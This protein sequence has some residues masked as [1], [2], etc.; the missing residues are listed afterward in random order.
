MISGGEMGLPRPETRG[1]GL[2]L[3]PMTEAKKKMKK[4][5]MVGSAPSA[6]DTLKNAS[7]ST[8]RKNRY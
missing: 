1:G 2:P 7:D 4:G 8:L 6:M 5:S 3:S